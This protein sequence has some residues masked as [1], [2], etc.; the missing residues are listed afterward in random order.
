MTLNNFQIE[1]EK[2]ILKLQNIYYQKITIIYL[3]Q[4]KVGKI[5]VSNNRNNNVCM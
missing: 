3:L 4:E 2:L 1:R 5:D